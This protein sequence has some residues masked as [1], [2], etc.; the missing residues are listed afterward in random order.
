MN[1][2]YG[3]K[4]IY[5]LS[6]KGVEGF[7]KKYGVRNPSNLTSVV[8]KRNVTKFNRLF[9]NLK[10]TAEL[11]L[12]KEHFRVI[13]HCS[14]CDNDI[15]LHPAF[16]VKRLEICT[17]ICTHCNP[18]IKSYREQHEIIDFLKSFYNKTIIENDRNT[19]NRA[20]T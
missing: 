17:E 15:E 19:L 4:W 5:D 3:D 16:Y 10:E 11:K 13:Y 12:D 18:V 7:R 14:K 1:D 9:P 8:L 2:K 6:K 20:R